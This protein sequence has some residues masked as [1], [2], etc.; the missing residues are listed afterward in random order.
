MNLFND[1]AQSPML[2]ALGYA[3]V[4]G[5]TPQLGGGR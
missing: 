2:P 1:V 3:S 5:G 4:P